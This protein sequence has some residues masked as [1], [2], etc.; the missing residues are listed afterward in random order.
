MLYDQAFSS[1][2]PPDGEL[3]LGKWPQAA[4][5]ARKL[6]TLLGHPGPNLPVQPAGSGPTH[7]FSLK[8]IRWLCSRMAMR[9]L[10]S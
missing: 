10:G 7:L 5:A 1:P 4:E 8:R 3:L 6:V 2:W 9:A